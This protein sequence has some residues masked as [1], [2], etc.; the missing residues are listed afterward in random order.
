M[1]GFVWSPALTLFL[2]HPYALSPKLCANYD[3]SRQRKQTTTS[4][5]CSV[6]WS[7]AS[8]VCLR[9]KTKSQTTL[10]SFSF[11]FVVVE[12]GWKILEFINLLQQFFGPKTVSHDFDFLRHARCFIRACIKKGFFLKILAQKKSHCENRE[13]GERRRWLIKGGFAGGN[14]WILIEDGQSILH[15][16]VRG[17]AFQKFMLAPI[18]GLATI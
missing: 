9:G 5:S 15:R 14:D 17:S 11:Y 13:W 7:S 12:F 6:F 10:L 2:R 18:F 3:D 1:G 4:S 8:S 16:L